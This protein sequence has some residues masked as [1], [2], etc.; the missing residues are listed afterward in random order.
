[1]K[2]NKTIIALFALLLVGLIAFGAFAYPANME[3]MGQ[4][5]MM[6]FED[7]L[8]RDHFRSEMDNIINSGYDAWYAK[9]S[10]V[11]PNSRMLSIIN[12]DNFEK[13]IE[14]HN[15][16]IA[17]DFEKANEIALEL[18]IERGTGIAQGLHKGQDLS[19]SINGKA[20]HKGMRQGSGLRDGSCLQ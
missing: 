19:N 7:T 16:K 5:R 11:N 20:Q 10:E 13:M 1:M 8:A 14:M 12:T 17:G 9:I 4:G 6:N 2:K 3:A 15:A 18:G